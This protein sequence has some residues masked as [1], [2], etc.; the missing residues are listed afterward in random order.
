MTHYTIDHTITFKCGT[1]TVREFSSS[2]MEIDELQ[3]LSC[4]TFPT[5]EYL[6][7]VLEWAKDDI[8]QQMHERLEYMMQECSWM[9]P[10]SCEVAVSVFE[11]VDNGKPDDTEVRVL[12]E[13]SST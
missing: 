12:F 6:K 1:Q 7:K 2:E 11:V 13:V 9:I 8:E 5:G 3:A 4:C 10:D